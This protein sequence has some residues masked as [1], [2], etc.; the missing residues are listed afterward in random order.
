MRIGRI[1]CLLL[2]SLLALSPL[3]TVLAQEAYELVVLP[4]LGRYDTV[5]RE[6]HSG[7]FDLDINNFTSS[8]YDKRSN[9]LPDM[10]SYR[11]Y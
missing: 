9:Y 5:V 1:I 11:K 6:G 8:E 4:S 10:W 2:V 7:D 3:G